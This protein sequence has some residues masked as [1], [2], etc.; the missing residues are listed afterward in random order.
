M[1]QEKVDKKKELKANR[2]DIVK[3]KK[4]QNVVR[5]AVVALVAVL[6]VLWMGISGYS[7]YEAYQEENPKTYSVNINPISDYEA[8][9]DEE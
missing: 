2:K 5:G 7:K 3:K 9:L 4:I 8:T 6:A 1:S